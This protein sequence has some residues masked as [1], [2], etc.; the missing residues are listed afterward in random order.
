MKNLENWIEINVIDELDDD[1]ETR[2]ALIP[3][4]RILFMT[5]ENGA[6]GLVIEGTNTPVYAVE[7]LS[8]IKN[9]LAEK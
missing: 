9:L 3:I 8:T 4:N 1:A 5:E 6:T 7:T 2:P